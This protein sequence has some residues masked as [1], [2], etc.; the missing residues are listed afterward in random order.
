M[1]ISPLIKLDI[2]VF[3][4][5]YYIYKLNQLTITKPDLS[6]KNTEILNDHSIFKTAPSK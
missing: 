1:L 5:K 3:V 2:S 6:S 4:K